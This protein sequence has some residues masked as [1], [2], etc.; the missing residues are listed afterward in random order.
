MLI[1]PCGSGSHQGRNAKQINTALRRVHVRS[2]KINYTTIGYILRTVSGSGLV[3]VTKLESF[4]CYM[5]RAQIS[6]QIQI[7]HLHSFVSLFL[8]GSYGF[9]CSMLQPSK[10]IDVNVQRKKAT[11]CKHIFYLYINYKECFHILLHSVIFHVNRCTT[12]V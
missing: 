9:M 8:I 5:K 4:T 3:F 6:N 7:N 12:V 1:L 10:D 11:H 2:Q